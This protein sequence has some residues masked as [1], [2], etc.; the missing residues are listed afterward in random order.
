MRVCWRLAVGDLKK[1]EHI[2]AAQQIHKLDRDP[3][4]RRREILRKVHRPVRRLM[5]AVIVC[6]GTDPNMSAG[7]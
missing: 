5:M 4:N 1:T 3:F 6:N 2:E 7:T